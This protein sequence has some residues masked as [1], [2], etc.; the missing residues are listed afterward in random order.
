MPS[1]VLLDASALLNAPHFSF[2]KNTSYLMPSSVLR[3]LRNPESRLLAENALHRKQLALRDPSA[4]LLQKIRQEAEEKGFS[5]LSPPDLEILALARELHEQG[6]EILVLTDDYSIQNFLLAWHIPFQ[7]ISEK[8][9]K[10]KITFEIRC[11]GCGKKFPSAHPPAS[12]G[13]CG[14][15]LERKRSPGPRVSRFQRAG[16]QP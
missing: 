9:V 4:F 5:R 7:G 3:E 6:K 8:G 15:P 1:L 13:D 14:A 11:T 2:K 10:G 12:C 16:P